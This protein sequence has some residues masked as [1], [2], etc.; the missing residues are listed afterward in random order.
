[1]SE[2]LKALEFFSGIGGWSCGM[3]LLGVDCE[4]VQAF[5]INTAANEVYYANHRLKPNAKS[6]VNLSS[7]YLDQFQSHI[8][9]CR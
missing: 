1:M 8:W 9:F 7:S 4:V 3:K 6:I 2:S 5:D